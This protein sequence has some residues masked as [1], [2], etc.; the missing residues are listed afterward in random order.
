M[1][2]SRPTVSDDLRFWINECFDWFDERFEPPKGP[3]LP[4][5]AFFN[6]QTGTNPETAEFVLEDIKRHM[7]FKA[8]VN[9][10]PLNTLPAE[11]RIDFQSL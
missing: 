5:K 10:L 7:N 11:N 4:T 1:F 2:W 9:I 3:V 8:E 6:A